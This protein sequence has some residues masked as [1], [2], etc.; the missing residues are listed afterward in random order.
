MLGNG[1]NNIV[2]LVTGYLQNGNVIGTDYL[3]N[4]GHGAANI[5][6]RRLTLR[7]VFGI[8]F[9]AKGRTCGVK[10]NSNVVGIH[11]L[12]NV[13]KCVDESENSTGVFALRVDAR[14]TNEGV[15]CT[16]YKRV[17]VKQVKRLH[18][19][20]EVINR[21]CNREVRT[22]AHTTTLQI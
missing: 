17:G 12:E 4:N 14:G 1:A 20:G 8:D 11:R 19:H 9:V 16:E 7:L 21:F 13:F 10:S 15:V 3:L 5:F 6:G 18:R 2:G 22:T